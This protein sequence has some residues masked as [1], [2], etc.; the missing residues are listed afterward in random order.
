MAISYFF[1]EYEQYIPEGARSRLVNPWSSYYIN[2]AAMKKE[3][4][5]DREKVRL[6][7]LDV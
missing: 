7:I 1:S 3:I 4:V 6:G 2:P 5:E